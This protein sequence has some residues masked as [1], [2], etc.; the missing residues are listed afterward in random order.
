MI[1]AKCVLIAL[2]C[3]MHNSWG[4]IKCICKQRR[5]GKFAGHTG[6]ISVMPDIV[7]RARGLY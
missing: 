3:N 1:I 6:K 7:D 2:D 4:N 5:V